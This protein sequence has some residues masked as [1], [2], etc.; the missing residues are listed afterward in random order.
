M[1]E[2]ENNENNQAA[3]MDRAQDTNH[4]NIVVLNREKS[5]QPLAGNKQCRS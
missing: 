5:R 4:T 3:T 1:T 2:R